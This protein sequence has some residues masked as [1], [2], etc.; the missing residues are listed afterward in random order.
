MALQRRV[1]RHADAGR[2]A[3]SAQGRHEAAA[4]GAHRVV[5]GFGDA[6]DG[7]EARAGG[8]RRITAH[9]ERGADVQ[10][11]AGRVRLAGAQR[12]ELI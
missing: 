4:Q 8:A 7:A 10:R 9:G 12:E 3:A 2:A 11:A 6:R 5:L 1:R